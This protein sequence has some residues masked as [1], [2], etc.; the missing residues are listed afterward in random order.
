[1]DDKRMTERIRKAVTQRCESLTPDPFLAA[2]V[3]RMAESKGD[4]KVRKKMPAALVLCIVL[5]LMSLTAV[6]AVALL[7][8][9]ELVEQTAPS[10]SR[11]MT[12]C[13]PTISI[14]MK[15]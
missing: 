13:A 12:T 10:P 5:M 2:R 15:S 4:I 14:P 11:T 7:S 8:G 3:M 6:A 1:M 9:Q